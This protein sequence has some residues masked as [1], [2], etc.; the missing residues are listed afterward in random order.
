MIH[1]QVGHGTIGLRA[2]SN[3]DMADC[4]LWFMV[5]DE[6]FMAMMVHGDDGSRLMVHGD[7]GSWLM[8]QG[9]IRFMINGSRFMIIHYGREEKLL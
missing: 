5:H 6:W 1:R 2:T 4:H 8:V 9:H 7:D 3:G